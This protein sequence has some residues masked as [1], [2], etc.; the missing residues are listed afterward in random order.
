MVKEVPSWEADDGSIHKS[1]IAALEHDAVKALMKLEVFNTASA[2]AIVKNVL[3]VDDV[4]RPLAD[5]ARELL[6]T[7][8]GEKLA[9]EVT[10][11]T[12]HA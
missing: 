11:E 10:E 1:K 8:C 7:A 3:K 6:N 4:L 2:S 12:H 5:E 9:V